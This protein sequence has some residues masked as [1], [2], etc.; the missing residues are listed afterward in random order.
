MDASDR[1]NWVYLDLDS[2]TIVEPAN[3]DDST[4]WD[5]AFKRY[6]IKVNGGVS[7]TGG[8]EI[9]GFEG[10]YDSFEDSTQASPHGWITDEP[11]AGG[12]TEYAVGTWNDYD[13]STHV[14]RPAD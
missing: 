8:V 3:P 14:V 13:F 4:E 6:D 1:D 2:R 10:Y 12:Q 9:A 5:M 7:G 11:A